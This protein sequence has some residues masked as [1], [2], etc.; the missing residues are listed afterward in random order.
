MKITR[1]VASRRLKRT[2]LEC[3]KG[4]VKGEVYYLNRWVA[5][6]ELG[7][8]SHEHL[9]CSKCDYKEKRYKQRFK[10]FQNEC[11]HPLEFI[12][13]QYRYIPG[14]AVMEPDYDECR[15]C[16]QVV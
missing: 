13:T 2:C 4:F 15:L 8:I 10:A 6:G 16:N 9:I 1:K 11:V 12:D 3:N 7:V 14:E 5:G